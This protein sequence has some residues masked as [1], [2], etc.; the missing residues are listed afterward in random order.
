[1][2]EVSETGDDSI[3]AARRLLRTLNARSTVYCD[4][5]FVDSLSSAQR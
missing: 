2:L 1:M 4:E 5:R 3:F